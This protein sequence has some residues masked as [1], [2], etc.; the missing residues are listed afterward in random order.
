[1]KF[2]V[3]IVIVIRTIVYG[4]MFEVSIKLDHAFPFF[5]NYRFDSLPGSHAQLDKTRVVIKLQN[6][7]VGISLHHSTVCLVTSV[8]S[9]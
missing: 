1:M 7:I 2:I 5:S 3:V 9:F 8:H 4:M 6:T